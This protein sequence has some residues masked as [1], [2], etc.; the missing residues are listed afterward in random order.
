MPVLRSITANPAG[1]LWLGLR[2]GDL[3]SFKNAIVK[4]YPYH[5]G[6]SHYL[7]QIVQN[8]DGSLLGADLLSVVGWKNGR[9]STLDQ[10][11]G[12]PCN[13]VFTITKDHE[14]S[15]WLYMRCGVVQLPKT[16]LERWWADPKAILKPT[17][18]DVSN[19]ADAGPAPFQSVATTPDGK[20]WFS[21]GRALQ[22][23]DPEK[24]RLNIPS[25]P[26]V[27]IEEIVADGVTYSPGS[28]VTLPKRTRQLSIRYTGL[29]FAAP[30]RVRFRYKLEGQDTDWQDAGYRREAIY[31]NLHS[32]SYTFEVVAQSNGGAWNVLGDRAT[33]M[34]PPPYNQ[35]VWFKSLVFLSLILFLAALYLFRIRQIAARI[36]IE[37]TARNQERLRI[38]RE[39]HDTLL[40]GFQGLVL[41]FQG[42]MKQIRLEDPARSKMEVILDQADQV[43]LQSRQS[44]RDLRDEQAP[45]SALAFVLAQV[46]ESYSTLAETTFALSTIGVM[47]PIC[48]QVQSEI[49]RI[50]TE[51]LVNAFRHAHA[52]HI[53]IELNCSDKRLV[54]TI[55]D[56]GVG[57][58]EDLLLEG[59][60]G[61]WGIRG[62]RERS[63]SMGGQI[64][65]S[66]QKN[67]G[68]EVRLIV[69]ANVAFGK[70]T[71]HH[72]HPAW[73]RLFRYY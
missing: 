72:D 41:R 42:A 22:M 43:L 70:A 9:L 6:P 23:V 28:P 26:P 25:P 40:Q 64:E 14:D 55:R 54:V 61:H 4:I 5:L 30:F 19:G 34:I 68:T 33:V 45:A 63:N 8:D 37:A 3:A 60:P 2:N 58:D 29:D 16:E 69:P 46:A 21:S 10:S 57:I 56:D 44:I 59:R 15:I 7:S 13:R 27:H 52:K 53:L 62:M 20:L 31:T 18:Y 73:T 49:E 65:I 48:F 38:S 17:V 50:G 24:L 51:A 11:N 35:T 67:Q 32:R 12:L 39:L 71:L 36:N 47:R 1:G 66:T